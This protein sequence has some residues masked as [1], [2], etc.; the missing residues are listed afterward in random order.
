MHSTVKNLLDI[1]SNSKTNSSIDKSN[2]EIGQIIGAIDDHGIII[3]TNDAPLV[4]TRLML[5]GKKEVSK[6]KLF[7]CFR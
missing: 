4:I 5:E 1:E 7:G 2:F 3:Q 6:K